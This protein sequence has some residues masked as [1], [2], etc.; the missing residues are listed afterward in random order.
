MVC[1]SANNVNFKIS[2]NYALLVL[3]VWTKFK[4]I[5]SRWS[6][7]ILLI[8]YCDITTASKVWNK[9]GTSDICTKL[10]IPSI[11]AQAQAAEVL[12]KRFAR[13]NWNPLRN[14]RCSGWV[15]VQW[16]VVSWTV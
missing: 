15:K 5:I 11:V 14:V 6:N 16:E 12:T 2:K 10:L 4:N 1:V 3:F 8:F 7:V 9:F 13:L